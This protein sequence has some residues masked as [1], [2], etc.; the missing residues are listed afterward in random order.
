M[1]FSTREKLPLNRLDGKLDGI[2]ISIHF[3]RPYIRRCL[4][5]STLN[6]AWQSFWWMVNWFSGNSCFIHSYAYW[7]HFIIIFSTSKWK[8]TL[9]LL[10]V[11]CWLYNCIFYIFIIE[12]DFKIKWY[13]RKWRRRFNMGNFLRLSCILINKK[14][15][16]EK[17]AL[18]GTIEINWIVHCNFF[19][20]ISC[21]LF[22]FQ[23]VNWESNFRCLDRYPDFIYFIF[24]YWDKVLEIK[25]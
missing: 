14:T 8:K 6:L 1:V 12:M 18:L 7:M 2:H 22:K 3:N 23:I 19:S 25:T 11:F 20:I 10:K 5:T 15:F 13:L 21:W 16:T 4:I 9:W 17:F 24:V